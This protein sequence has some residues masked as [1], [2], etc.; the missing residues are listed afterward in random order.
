MTMQKIAITVP[1]EV[2]RGAK[3]AVKAQ[4]ARSLSSYVSAA[5]AE[6]LQRDNLVETLDAMDSEL[7]PPSKASQAW[8]KKLLRK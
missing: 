5:L 8:A 6:K 1:E 2:L 7:G 4:Q 3:R